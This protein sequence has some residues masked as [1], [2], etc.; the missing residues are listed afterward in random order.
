MKYII[1]TLLILLSTSCGK[2]TEERNNFHGSIINFQNPQKINI[3]NFILDYDTIR[4]ELNE[5]S[6]L[7]G[8]SQIHIMDDNLYILSSNEIYIFS[9]NGKYI[10]KISDIGNGPSEYIKIMSFEIDYIHKKIILSDSFSKR[11]FI[12]D[13][14]GEQE[15]VIQLKNDLFWIVPNN[16][17]FINMYPTRERYPTK[18]MEDYSV[19]HLDING[20]FK[21]GDI[22]K[23]NKKRIDLGSKNMIECLEDGKILYQPLL[24]DTIFLINQRE[25]TPFYFINNESNLKKLTKKQKSEMAFIYPHVNSFK[26]KEEQNYLLPLGN[27]LN[28][29]DYIFTMF[30]AW[31]TEK[32]ILVYYSK[33]TNKAISISANKATGNNALKKLFL[34]PPYTAYKDKF[35]IC[36]SL[37]TVEEC[38]PELEPGKLKTFFQNTDIE[39]NPVIISFRINPE[40]FNN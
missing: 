3:D 25:I 27:V 26:E 12:Y 29:D 11:I 1:F 28:S 24:S 32:T 34:S 14:N 18:E 9:Q 36:P 10:S 13:K 8:I 20:N 39:S 30:G 5:N 35:Y 7:P 37:F 22:R 40:I 16:G 6:I 15:K 2:N 4:L 17:E 21:T 19:H 33:E 31:D 23:E 38:A